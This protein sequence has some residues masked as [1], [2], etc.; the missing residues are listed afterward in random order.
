MPS[1]YTGNIRYS[2]L[3]SSSSRYSCIYSISASMHSKSVKLGSEVD[4]RMW[5]S[6]L[7]SGG[8]LTLRLYHV[9]AGSFFFAV[10]QLLLPVHPDADPNT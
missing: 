10:D 9:F 1:Q 3:A 7:R 2:P 8:G 5:G 6:R 4:F